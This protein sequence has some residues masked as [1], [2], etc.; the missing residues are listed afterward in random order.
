MQRSH[1]KQDENA[2]SVCDPGGTLSQFEKLVADAAQPKFLFRLY[3]AGGSTRSR[4]AIT[5]IRKICDEYLEGRYELDVIDVYQQ[6]SV[7]RTAEVIVLPTLIKEMPFP[8]K[9]FVG[10]M[11]N[12]ERIVAGLKLRS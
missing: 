4:V 10:D 5:N 1:H 11:S 3:V 9:R 6:P 7:T 12:T 8:P 2:E